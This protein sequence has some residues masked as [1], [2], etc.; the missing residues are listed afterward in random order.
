MAK[1]NDLRFIGQ[2]DGGVRRENREG[3][4]DQREVFG[5]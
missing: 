2:K 3:G 1:D 5:S 4:R